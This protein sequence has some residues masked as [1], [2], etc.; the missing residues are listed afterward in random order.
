[1][2]KENKRKWL[3][4]CIIILLPILVGL[5]LWDK[6]PEIMATHWG[7]NGEPD[8]FNKKGFVVF[9]MPLIL[10]ALHIVCVYVTKFGKS[11]LAQNKKV[12]GLMYWMVPVVVIFTFGIIYA[13]ALGRTTNVSFVAPLLAGLLFVCL[14]N[15]LP[16]LKQNYVIGIKIPWTLKDEENWNKTHRLSGKLWV[17]GGFVVLLSAFTTGE[18]AFTIMLVAILVMVLV[19]VIYSYTFFRKKQNQSNG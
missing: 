3:I 15:Y 11:Q 5:L 7:V 9:G 6:L 2:M 16:K 10:L 1:M 12:A 19:P 14:G 13:E 17:V 4:S 8:G 18:M